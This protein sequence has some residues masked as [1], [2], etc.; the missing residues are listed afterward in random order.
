MNKITKQEKI[1]AEKLTENFI[2]H[3]SHKQLQEAYLFLIKKYTRIK[4]ELHV[5]TD[6]IECFYC[7]NKE[8]CYLRIA[9]KELIYCTLSDLNM[10]KCT[11]L[12]K[13]E[14]VIA[15]NCNYFKPTHSS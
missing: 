8:L 3:A 14:Q 11:G 6:K 15:H 7:T 10:I 12:T 9:L 2:N 1:F 13:I 4:G 5:N